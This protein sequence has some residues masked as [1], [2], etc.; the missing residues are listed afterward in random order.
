MSLPNYGSTTMI[1]NTQSQRRLVPAI[2]LAGIMLAAC[3]RPDDATT[4]TTAPPAVTTPAPAPVD[5]AVTAADKRADELRADASRTGDAQQGAANMADRAGA[6]ISDATITT[7]VKAALAADD[8]LSALQ[9]N[10][11]TE[12]GVV[13][14]TGPAPDEISRTRATELAADAK[15]VNRVENE[16]V[17][18][19]Q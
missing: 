2:A 15:G 13:K 5:P 4:T 10:V 6:A 16:L 14:L 8:K 1:L 19:A 18:R 11:D 7:S 12:Q 17:V 3:G 9:I